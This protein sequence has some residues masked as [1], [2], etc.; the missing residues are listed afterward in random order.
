MI[1]IYTINRIIRP[2]IAAEDDNIHNEL[3]RYA[4]LFTWTLFKIIINVY[5]RILIRVSDD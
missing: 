5:E 2:F 3:Q 1:K 4:A